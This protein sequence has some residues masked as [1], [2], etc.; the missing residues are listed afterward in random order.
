MTIARD[1]TDKADLGLYAGLLEQEPILSVSHL[2]L[3]SELLN[4]LD[5]TSNN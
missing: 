5:S 2:I 1:W 4:K 3:L